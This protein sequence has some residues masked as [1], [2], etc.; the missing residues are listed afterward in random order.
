MREE[1]LEA[2]AKA[3]EVM[4]SGTVSGAA[5]EHLPSFI[6]TRRSL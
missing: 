6:Q 3:V 5:E 1:E 2:I 4:S